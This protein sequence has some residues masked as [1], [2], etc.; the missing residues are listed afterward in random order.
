MSTME[1]GDYRRRDSI[2]SGDLAQEDAESACHRQRLQALINQS[3]KLH[4][5]LTKATTEAIEAEE[6]KLLTDVLLVAK[7][8]EEFWMRRYGKSTPLSQHL[9]LAVAMAN[10]EIVDS[11]SHI[12]CL[13]FH[14]FLSTALTLNFW[15]E[16]QLE[17]LR[18]VAALVEAQMSRLHGLF[19]QQRV[20]NQRNHKLLKRISNP[21]KKARGN[22][23]HEKS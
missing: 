2:S 11:L 3:D 9:L 18:H 4:D 1:C 22:R 14:S 12:C 15:K 20:Q 19:D 21:R 6:W 23:K 16:N 8:D 5:F 13:N 17:Q 10:S 7:E